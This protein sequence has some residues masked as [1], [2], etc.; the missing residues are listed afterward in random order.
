MG[1]YEYT[2]SFNLARAKLLVLIGSVIISFYLVTS[3]YEIH[4]QSQSYYTSNNSS[5]V[6]IP[7]IKVGN[8][9]ACISSYPEKNLIYV[10]NAA[11][12]TISV[13]DGAT[14]TVINTI[15]VGEN[16]PVTIA[17]DSLT[18][19]LYV[20]A[21]YSNTLKEID[22]V[23]N[24]VIGSIPIENVPESI[25]SDLFG[26]IFVTNQFSE[27]ITTILAETHYNSTGYTLEKSIR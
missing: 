8:L 21:A 12:N 18:N 25:V 13:I 22:T 11:S 20:G 10:C 6:D 27:N 7:G 15:F 17:L 16:F 14:N 1:T 4:A 19:R 9:P 23:T 3:T 2:V 24:K 5:G 26:H